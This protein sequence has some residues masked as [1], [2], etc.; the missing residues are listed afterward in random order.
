MSRRYEKKYRKIDKKRDRVIRQ[1]HRRA[2]N[3]Q[4]KYGV[5][6]LYFYRIHTKRCGYGFSTEKRDNYQQV[7]TTEVL[8]ECLFGQVAIL[9]MD[10]DTAYDSFE[11][12]KK[13]KLIIKLAQI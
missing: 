10:T 11:D 1:E 3:L 2:K 9:N 5:G 8:K 12:Y 4:L 6:N 13:E 7:R